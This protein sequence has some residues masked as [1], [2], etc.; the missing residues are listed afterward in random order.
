MPSS[1]TNINLTI[2][3][4]TDANTLLFDDYWR[5]ICFDGDATHLSA[6]QKID[7]AFEMLD[8]NLKLIEDKYELPTEYV[9]LKYIESTGTQYINTQHYHTNAD[10][11]II[12][13]A[14][15]AMPSARPAWRK[16]FGAT[17]SNYASPDAQILECNALSSGDFTFRCIWQ[18]NSGIDFGYYSLNAR[19]IIEM[20]NSYA[21]SYLQSTYEVNGYAEY[22]GNTVNCQKPDYLFTVNGS[23]T[24]THAVACR[25]YSFKVIRNDETIVDLLPCY[26]ASTDTTGMY[27][28]IND[29]FLENIGTGDFIRG[30]L[31]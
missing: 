24:V 21:A 5:S 11:Y 4:A 19:Y 17:T 9:A 16:A 30:P 29:R 1:T 28:L 2:Y 20:T 18:P 27:D 3:D 25:I 31:A 13:I 15:T 12:D 6:F 7:K 23:E 14:I 8:A 10:K 26:K 22:H